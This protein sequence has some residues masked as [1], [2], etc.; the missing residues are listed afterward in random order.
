MVS[1]RHRRCYLQQQRTES[2][3]APLIRALRCSLHRCETGL[4][5]QWKNWL[6]AANPRLERTPF[7]H[8]SPNDTIAAPEP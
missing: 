8:R 3:P 1:N 4:V 6:I 2:P 5:S 7:A